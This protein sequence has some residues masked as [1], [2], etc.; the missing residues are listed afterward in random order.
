MSLLSCRVHLIPRATSFGRDG[1]TLSAAA[2]V[3][4]FADAVA[5]FK[6][7]F[8]KV[9]AT[10]SPAD[11]GSP[12]I[13]FDLGDY[14]DWTEL[15][16]VAQVLSATLGC[17]G[18]AL[19]YYE[20]AGPMCFKLGLF[21]AGEAARQLAF[22]IDD[23]WECV[24]GAALPWEAAVFFDDEDMELGALVGGELELRL[25]EEFGVGS[26]NY[27]AYHDRTVVQGASI[28]SPTTSTRP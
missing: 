1:L 18:L 6:A 15:A 11:A 17:H 2:A 28:R 20:G 16:Q 23:G 26:A 8:G 5:A 21:T 27:R 25:D 7:G 19:L 14:A 4:D 9:R 12:W 22:S 3:L 24:E 13:T 10:P